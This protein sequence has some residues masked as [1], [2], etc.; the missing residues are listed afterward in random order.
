MAKHQESIKNLFD[1]GPG[2]TQVDKFDKKYL[3]YVQNFH[4]ASALNAFNAFRTKDLAQIESTLKNLSNSVN[5][6][7]YLIGIGALIIERERLF[8]TAGFPS[9][10]EYAQHLFEDL[11]LPSSTVGDAKIIMERYIDYNRPL[12]KAGFELKG[13]ANKLRY[14]EEALQN[15]DEEEVFSRIA[16][17]T[18][19][20]FRDWAQRKT[21]IT[22]KPGPEIRVDVTI[23]GNKLLID[24]KNILNFPRG[25]PNILKDMVSDDLKK[26]FSIREGGNLP[27]IIDTYGRGE[28]TAIENFIKKYRSKK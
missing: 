19:R 23:K 26:T 17:D 16:E 9:Y 7:M 2:S 6:N 12:K 13:N 21:F 27:L 22:H 10:I 3:K 24:G 11:E 1:D 28:Q 14:L 25:I 15:H 20:T 5:T 4:D 18:F 8:I